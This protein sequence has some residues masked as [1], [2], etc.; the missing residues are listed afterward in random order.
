MRQRPNRAIE[1]NQVSLAAGGKVGHSQAEGISARTTPMA[2]AISGALCRATN[3][4][5]GIRR[6]VQGADQVLAPTA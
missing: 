4:A 6:D 2:T 5:D 1:N 3:G